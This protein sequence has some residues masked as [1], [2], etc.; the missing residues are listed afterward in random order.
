MYCS[1][2]RTFRTRRQRARESAHYLA[3]HLRLT[4]HDG[5]I[6]ARAED[7]RNFLRL[8]VR[9]R[10]EVPGIQRT[11]QSGVAIRFYFLRVLQE[12]V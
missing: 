9:Y 3:A 8:Y 11:L 10:T 6:Q 1:A 5:A 2:I 4:N 7:D 12:E